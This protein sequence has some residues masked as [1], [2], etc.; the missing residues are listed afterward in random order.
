M[1]KRYVLFLYI[2]LQLCISVSAQ[3]KWTKKDSLWLKRVL[4]GKEKVKLN[5]EAL[6]AINSG[7]LISPSPTTKNQLKLSPLE[8][9][10]DQTL[11]GIT[12]P[13]TRLNIKSIPPS[14]FILYNLNAG[15]SPDTSPDWNTENKGSCMLNDKDIEEQK[16]LMKM[17]VKKAAVDDPQTIPSPGISFNAEDL[18]RTIF[19]PSHRAKKHNAKHANAYKNFFVAPP[20]NSKDEYERRRLNEYI[21]RLN[22]NRQESLKNKPEKTD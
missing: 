9:P 16:R 18:L 7:T 17:Y 19:W 5:D 4:S 22:K 12:R 10:I 20:S 6:R 8:L 14:I 1:E 15:I 2:G 3:E 11:D 21:N 13:P